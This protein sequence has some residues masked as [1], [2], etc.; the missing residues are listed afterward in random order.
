MF[1]TMSANEIRWPHL[2]QT[3][4]RLSDYYKHIDDVSVHNALNKLNKSMRSQLVNED[5]VVCCVLL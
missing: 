5:P 2:L 1:L 4:H 3:L